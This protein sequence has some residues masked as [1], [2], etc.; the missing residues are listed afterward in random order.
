VRKRHWL[1]LCGANSGKYCLAGF[2]HGKFGRKD[3]VNSRSVPAMC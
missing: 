2:S 1:E 3:C